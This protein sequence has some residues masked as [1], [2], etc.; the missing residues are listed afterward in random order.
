MF[1][2]ALSAASQSPLAVSELDAGIEP[3]TVAHSDALTMLN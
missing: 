3:R 2:T 1:N